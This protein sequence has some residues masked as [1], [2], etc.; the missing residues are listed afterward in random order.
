M[1]ARVS[2]AISN[3]RVRIAAASCA[4][5]AARDHRHPDRVC[6]HGGGRLRRARAQMMYAHMPVHERKRCCAYAH[7]SGIASMP[8]WARGWRRD[9]DHGHNCRKNKKIHTALRNESMTTVRKKQKKIEHEG[10]LS[11]C[12]SCLCGMR[13]ERHRECL[14][15]NRSAAVDAAKHHWMQHEETTE[16]P[17][18]SSLDPL[19]ACMHSI[20]D[21]V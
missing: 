13:K 14:I 7:T 6:L 15:E 21:D 12:C 18:Q 9:R 16:V 2:Q 4:P 11:V 17:V 1:A 20:H 5:A 8:A 3:K 19:C 10:S